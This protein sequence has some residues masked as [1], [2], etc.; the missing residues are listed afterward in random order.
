[1]GIVFIDKQ[2][3]S[4][5]ITFMLRAKDDDMADAHPRKMLK[6]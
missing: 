1:M 3:E 5:H 6:G 2:L 4:Q